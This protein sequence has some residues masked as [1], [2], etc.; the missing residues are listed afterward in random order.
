MTGAH[1]STLTRETSIPLAKAALEEKVGIPADTVRLASASA[2][3]WSNSSL[4]CPEKGVSYQPVVTSG[5]VVSLQVESRTYIVHVAESASVICNK[6]GMS[7]QEANN[8]RLD[9]AMQPVIR[10]REDLAGRLNVQPTQIEV[11]TIKRSIWPD[12]SLGCPRP[13]ELYTQVE[14]PGFVV[15][16]E[17]G[18]SAYRYHVSSTAVMLCDTGSAS[19]DNR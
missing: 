15:E 14:T 12:S 6:A 18:G 10:A 17:Q 9:Q 2:S 16:F 7:G 13:G 3:E 5:Y 19:G 8:A 4:G 11:S 1:A